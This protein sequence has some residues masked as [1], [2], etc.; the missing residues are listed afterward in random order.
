MRDRCNNSKNKSY[1]NY[2]GRG[3]RISPKWND[4][5]AFHTWAMTNDYMSGLTI[6]R[7]NNNGN[8]E[9]GNCRWATKK[10]QAQNFRRNRLI[11][12]NGA[13][14]TLGQWA[15]SLFMSPDALRSRLNGGWAV[16]KAL[17]TPI[18]INYLRSGPKRKSA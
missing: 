18:K 13:T 8:Y 6:E 10:E 4:Y 3:I 11:T 1:K 14:K 2:G 9:P 15:D 16:E 17:F 12:F 7:K 5:A